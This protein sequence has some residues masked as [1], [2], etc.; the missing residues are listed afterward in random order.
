MNGIDDRDQI[1]EQYLHDF[2]L[3]Y[4]FPNK[5]LIASFDVK[6]ILND[7]IYDNF[8]VQRPGRA[9]YIKLNYTLKNF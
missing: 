9:F 8:G 1:P 2:G 5:N 7:E 3:S 6:N 4:T